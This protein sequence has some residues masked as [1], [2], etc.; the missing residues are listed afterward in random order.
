MKQ[1]EFLVKTEQE[2]QI[3]DDFLLFYVLQG[4]VD[5]TIENK[6]Y[7]MSANDFLLVNV[8]ERHSYSARGTFLAA[9]FSISYS[10][11]SSMMKKNMLY[12]RCNTVVEEN[13]SCKLIRELV[14]K[15]VFATSQKEVNEIYIN[16]LY[17]SLLNVLTQDFIVHSEADENFEMEHKFDDRKRAI[18]E[19]IRS[20]YSRDISLSELANQLYL[21]NAYLSKYIKRQF[22]MSFLEYVNSVRLSYAV[23]QIHHSDKSVVHI[24]MDTGFASAAALNKA[25]REKYNMTPTEY[26]RQWVAQKEKNRAAVDE[27]K[28]I[29]ERVD[30]LIRASE[31]D[32]K[33]RNNRYDRQIT[34]KKTERKPL[35]KNW[36]QMIDVGSAEDLSLAIVQRQILRLKEE[37]HF[38]Y[39]RFWDLYSPAM[40]LDRHL[41]DNVYN[42]NRLDSILDFL[43]E[44]NLKPYI[45]LR[46]KPK[47]VIRNVNENLMVR[48]PEELDDPEA[49]RHF[50][51][52]LIIHL[53]NRYSTAEVESWYFEI[54]KTEREAYLHTTRIDDI[55][56]SI[57]KYLE[58]FD[59]IAG[60]L[61][62]YLP[63]IQVGGGG[64]S[65][66][67]GEESLRE[68]LIRWPEYKQLP[69]FVSIYA[70]PYTV[71][72]IDLKKNQS[73]NQNYLKETVFKV[74]Q[75]MAETGFPINTLHVSEW[76]FSVS[77]R[78][79]LND[80]CMKGAYIMKNL[81]D[82]I[83]HVEI[84]GYWT[85]TDLYSE[86][87]DS[88]SVLFGGGGIF[89]KYGIPKPAY[90]AYDFLD[91]LGKYLLQKGDNYII[92]SNGN[93]NFRICCH[94]L[95]GL[96][97]QYGLREENDIS[98]EQLDSMFEDLRPLALEFDLPVVKEGDYRINI[99]RLNQ[100]HGSLLDEWVKMGS[101]V[102][103]SKHDR[104]YL[105]RVSAP[106][107]NILETKSNGERL[108]FKVDLEP[109]EIMFIHATYLYD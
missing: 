92:T 33:R 52:S 8:D 26:R 81:M 89:N 64:F 50:M 12:F 56:D 97:F 88:V 3:S 57:T 24:A 100:K 46:K 22:G 103:L 69:N 47:K 76:N 32:M 58:R 16:S 53:I 90:Y 63:N 71:D 67:Y 10:T 40:F 77:N 4:S 109:N 49:E 36:N 82:T 83:D 20:N 41:K 25:F 38:Q 23:S 28:I 99:L 91:K 51:S 78:N 39:I 87:Y 15:V 11:L 9:C 61:R 102:Y 73:M 98:V 17:Y 66:R 80:H 14:Q 96:S 19:Y 85:M 72:S 42:F 84:I 54:W 21:S 7:R 31:S 60:C 1:F 34:L 48:E 74:R 104:E 27:E 59:S 44:H 62:S 95:K 86:Y 18:T 93:E 108:N 45:E 43:V 37:L 65:L 55:S 35:V 79:L 68:N 106:R 13:E 107:V 5:Y 2:T 30:G 29:R 101:P 6:K 75:I 94:N 105:N 70:Y